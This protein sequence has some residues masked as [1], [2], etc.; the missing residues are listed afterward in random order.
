[1]RRQVVIVGAGPSGIFAALRLAESGIDDVLL[2][3]A[4]KALD[5]RACPDRAS[6][7]GC[8]SCLPCGVLSGWGGAGA[9]SDG[10]LVLSPQVGGWLRE[11]LPPEELQ[12]RIEDVDGIM[13]RF[14][15][16]SPVHAPTPELIA[17]LSL[18]ATAAGLTYVPAPV[19]HLGTDGSRQV[20]DRLHGHLSGKV[21]VRFGVRVTGVVEEGGAAAGVTLEG[22]GAVG[23]RYVILAPGRS[24]APWLA[25]EGR[26]HRLAFFSN[27]VDLGVRVEIPGEVLATVTEDVYEAKLL[28]TSASF[29]DRVRSFCMCPWGEVVMES[30]DG[31]RT[32]NGRSWRERRSA[33]TNFALLV[34]TSFTRPFDDPLA[35]GRH[36]ASLANML[37]GGILVQR[38]GDLVAGK[39]ST[40]ERLAG[41]RVQPT[42]RSAEPG[43]LSFALPYRHLTD[44]R[45]MLSALDRFAPGIGDP[46][47]LLYGVEA[48]FYSL[49]PRRTAGMET[50]LRNLFAVGDGAGVSRGLV[51]SACSGLVAAEAILARER[52]S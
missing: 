38:L 31:I 43:D 6:G 28:F 30:A 15:A 40:R 13:V 41:N 20:L 25:A 47:T 10:K 12:R 27:P 29:G 37:G 42:L 11:L 44:L 1:M 18:R 3:E 34:G 46:S 49:R 16:G 8:R 14:G 39:R 19:R 2:L 4:G 48:K 45:E 9:W 26:R 23:A 51:Q 32:V 17:D 52:T 33:N 22:G 36:V 21:A 24:G 50:E 35:Y 7:A 5:Q